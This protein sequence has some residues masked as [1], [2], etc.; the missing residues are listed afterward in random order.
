MRRTLW[1]I[2]AALIVIARPLSAD[3]KTSDAYQTAMKNNGEAMRTV[4]SA[5][6]EI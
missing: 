6:K 5:A 1:V 2:G 4:R 3:D